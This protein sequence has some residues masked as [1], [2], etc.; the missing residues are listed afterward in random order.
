MADRERSGNRSAAAWAIVLGLLIAGY[1]FLSEGGSRIIDTR[2]GRST[3]GSSK[4]MT[5]IVGLAFAAYGAYS[6]YGQREDT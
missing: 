6:L 4:V 5:I 2:W 1:G 3:A